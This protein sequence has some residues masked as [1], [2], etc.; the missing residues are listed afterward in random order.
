MNFLSDNVIKILLKHSDD[1]VK[2]LND[3]SHQGKVSSMSMLMGLNYIEHELKLYKYV[4]TGAID[5]MKNL[6]SKYKLSNH[7][8][9]DRKLL[10]PQ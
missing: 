2:K 5:N 4:F 7:S 9:L 1:P 10:I 8:F 6:K 3:L